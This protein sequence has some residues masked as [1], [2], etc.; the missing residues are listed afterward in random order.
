MRL[1]KSL[2]LGNDYSHDEDEDE[3][4][5]FADEEMHT[6]V[7]YNL[8]PGDVIE[9]LQTVG[10]NNTMLAIFIRSMGLQ[11]LFLAEDGRWAAVSLLRPK[12]LPIHGFVDPAMLEPLMPFLPETS[13]THMSENHGMTEHF[14][15]FGDVPSGIV[16][17]F[18]KQLALLR[19]DTLGFRREH[20]SVM[21]RVHELLAHEDR[22]LIKSID[23]ATEQLFDKP[24]SGLS[25]GGRIAFFH[26][27]ESDPLGCQICKRSDSSFKLVLTPKHLVRKFEHVREWARQY[28][29]AAAQKATSGKNASSSS[30]DNPL[31]SF[32]DKARRII[33]KSRKIRSPTT[34][35]NLGP[36]TVRN[37]DE[38]N[39]EPTMTISE[40]GETFTDSDQMILEFIWNTYLRT[41]RVLFNDAG[42]SIASQIL[43]AI[44][45]YPSLRLESKIARLLFQELGLVSPWGEM[46]DDDVVLPVP[47]RRNG[48]EARKLFEESEQL[49]TELDFASPTGLRLEDSMAHLR[50][51]SS[52]TELVY[53]IDRTT[54]DLLDD[55]FS[56]EECADVPGAYWMH[57]HIAHPSA[58]IGPDHLFAERAALFGQALYTSQQ[59]FSM[60]P[61]DFVL[62]MSIGSGSP[63]LT[64]SSLILR[65]GEVKDVKMT[66]GRIKEAIRLNP[67][68]VDEL[69]GRRDPEFA[70]LTVGAEY[71]K[72]LH[73]ASPEDIRHV[74]KH[75]EVLKIAQ[76]I[77]Q[78]RFE[79]RM[80]EISDPL[81]LPYR[82]SNC[83]VWVT[84][85]GDT[86]TFGR[87]QANTFD[88]TH[89]RHVV[90]DPVI[91]ISSPRH[92]RSNL[93]SK[94]YLV[95]GLTSQMM[96]VASEMAGL[97]CSRREIP[98]VYQ[99]SLPRPG[100][101]PSQLSSR[102]WHD[103]A[104]E[105]RHQL[106]AT[107]RPH[108]LINCNQ[109]LKF[110]SPLRR[111]TDLIGLWQI[112]AYLR[113]EGKSP[114]RV[115]GYDSAGE[116]PFSRL[117]LEQYI[118]RNAQTI[119]D[120]D[121][122]MLRSKIHWT[123]QALFRAFHFKEATLPEVWDLYVNAVSYRGVVSNSDDSGLRGRLV[124]FHMNNV[125]VVKSEA[126]Y[127]K[128]ALI[129]QFLPVKIELVDVQKP[130]MYVKAVGPP[131]ARPTTTD[132][133]EI[134]GNTI[135]ESARP[136]EGKSKGEEQSSEPKSTRNMRRGNRV[137][138]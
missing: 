88:R 82:E 137:G 115:I 68:A 52:A 41:P 96:S 10:T 32:I 11:D 46:A 23:E 50:H 26:A 21:E 84:F 101:S 97:W 49:A 53:C 7:K 120:L 95:D 123:F 71:E 112:D 13:V 119:K 73:A 72:R 83:D 105:P 136:A 22:F 69:L 31:N 118:F 39:G 114:D 65:T 98:A 81:R 138:W 127:E 79:R 92:E 67:R 24:F 62:A 55:A 109:Y 129:G 132:R 5:G 38:S 42:Q 135:S 103:P 91:H 16:A 124:P 100:F 75:L 94:R 44:G 130:A 2:S 89:S 25:P 74:T 40:T 48:Y 134:G 102:Q 28:Q 57:V 116:L 78:A 99:A 93:Q 17:P 6:D 117:Q 20:V 19:D 90:G 3:D 108:V 107:A 86:N 122:L 126:G 66:P 76:Q 58:F 4:N 47:G 35:G 43:R 54:A 61:R 12:S 37:S 87:D 80:V 36:S 121:K 30:A 60:M 34:V 128:T 56:I 8:E 125:H 29:E 133:I 70:Y 63:C 110:T 113:Q 45:A 111:Y 18:T 104:M 85:P 14:L 15:T 33:L 9:L 27:L 59:T 64:V 131:S 106:S 1:K 51:E 77:C